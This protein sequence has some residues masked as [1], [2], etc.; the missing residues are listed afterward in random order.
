MAQLFSSTRLTDLNKVFRESYDQCRKNEWLSM[1][2]EGIVIV[3]KGSAPILKH[4]GQ[5]CSVSKSIPPVY[6]TWKS[7]SH[8]PLTIWLLARNGQ[9]DRTGRAN[10][11]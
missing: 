4:A 2:N 9:C 11:I 3:A 6:H 10:Q 5:V 1:I 7:I 8:I